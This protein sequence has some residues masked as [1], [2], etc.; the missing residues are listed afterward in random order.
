V[1]VDGVYAGG[2]PVRMRYSISVNP[3]REAIAAPADPQAAPPPLAPTDPPPAPPAPPLSS[4]P[5]PAAID[6]VFRVAVADQPLRVAFLYDLNPD[7]SLIGVPTVRILEPPKS[8]QVTV[9]KGAG[10]T[11]SPANNLRSKCN[12]DRT[13]GAVMTYVPNPGYKGM[14]TVVA[15]IIYPDGFAKKRRY[16]IE[17][18]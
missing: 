9:E 15:D 8:G 4:A 2:A 1:T 5:R 7:C 14:D 12:A 16:A 18:R 11:N 10:F 13:D 17:V 6:E 3:D